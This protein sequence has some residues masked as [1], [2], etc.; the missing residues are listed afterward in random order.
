[1][2]SSREALGVPGEIAVRIPPL[3]VPAP[4]QAIPLAALAEIEAVRLF[5]ERARAALSSFEL[6]GRN[7]AAV[8]QICQ[9]LDGIPLAL[10]LAAARV[11]V[12]QVEQIA[13]RLDD[14]FRL[15]TGGSRTALP[16][17]QTLLA[18]ID[19]SY[20][21]LP[22]A[23][24]RLLQR[25]SVFAG[26]WTLE[27][28]EAVCADGQISGFEILDLLTQLV[29]KSLVSA[30]RKSGQ[31]TRYGLLET[32]RQYAQEKLLQAGHGELF[33]RRHLDYF[34]QL[35]ETAEPELYRDNQ[36]LWLDRLD[37]E[38]DNL[39]AALGW[40]QE[41]EVD[42]G[43]R[44]ALALDRFWG[45]RGYEREAEGWLARLL[46]EPKILSANLRARG[47]TAQSEL[48]TAMF[49]L[50]RA[51][52]LAEESLSICRELGDQ[53]GTAINLAVIAR[54]RSMMGEEQL[55]QITIKQSLEIY[56]GLDDKSGLA[57]V[58]EAAAFLAGNS[59][60]FDLAMS[61]LAESEKLQ[62][63]A[64]DQ[65]GIA[66]DLG[67]LG[68]YAFYQGDFATARTKLEESLAIQ[69]P[70]GEQGTR[71]TLYYLGEL[72]LRQR[73]YEQA[74]LYFEKSYSLCLESGNTTHSYW[75][76]VCLGYVFLRMGLEAQARMIFAESQRQFR[77]V[78]S[79]IGVVFTLEGLASLA[80][81][82][83]QF[84]KAAQLFAWADA[85]REEILDIRPPSEQ[86]EVDQDIAASIA[87][88]GEEAFAAASMEGKKLTME[89]AVALALAE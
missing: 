71:L 48:H 85:K 45:T 7:G 86:A 26:G 41:T 5:V 21:L 80:V 11:K 68:Q 14:L 64:G 49:D 58:L 31:E 81:A 10:E 29:N 44:L 24:Q 22:E 27:A 9:R 82:Q 83:E 3:A 46:V 36:L 8:S 72:A 37:T 12:L 28:A 40:A 84:Q 35:A 67:R 13:Q 52:E 63:K 54:T 23:E 32:I 20:D 43:L 78:D 73:E 61:Y 6:T 19:W 65:M 62:R 1:L 47:I 15:L 55:A 56:K 69:E 33:R 50:L 53:R 4:E 18:T 76:Y 79:P 34:L 42:K 30:E 70:F 16:R 38:H 75:S 51:I 17:Q 88:I 66:Y 25:L 87:A 59:N 77:E 57:P 60:N 89:Q 2:A 39:R 74:R